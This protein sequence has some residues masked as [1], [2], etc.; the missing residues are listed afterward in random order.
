MTKKKTSR[1]GKLN[2]KDKAD[3][4]KRIREGEPSETIAA[5][6]DVS[7]KTIGNY[8]RRI[9][10]QIKIAD[11]P[12][13]QEEQNLLGDVNEVD[14]MKEEKEEGKVEPV[15]KLGTK[16]DVEVDTYECGN[17]GNKDLEHGVKRCPNCNVELDW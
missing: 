16:E 17:C 11:I 2:L 12:V 3:I 5:S 1:W 15:Q 13:K 6:Y 8:K 9:D 7:T 10:A 4:A 14:D